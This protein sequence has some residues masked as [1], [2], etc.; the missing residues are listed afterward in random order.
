[1]G[2]KLGLLGCYGVRDSVIKT[3]LE[4]SKPGVW[5]YIRGLGNRAFGIW[6]NIRVQGFSGE[7]PSCYFEAFGRVY[8]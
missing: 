8:V 3:G 1:M 4:C 2:R 6:E 5:A 7:C